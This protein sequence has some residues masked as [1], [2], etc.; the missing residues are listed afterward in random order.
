MISWPMT[1]DSWGALCRDALFEGDCDAG[2]RELCRLL[3]WEDELDALIEA[4][5]PP[6]ATAL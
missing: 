5:L 1:A 6:E 4:G 2:V 3:G